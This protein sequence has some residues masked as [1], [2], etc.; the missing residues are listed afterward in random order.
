M[1]IRSLWIA[2]LLITAST[3]SFALGGSSSPYDCGRPGKLIAVATFGKPSEMKEELEAWVARQWKILPPPIQSLFQSEDRAMAEW[4][5]DARNR[6]LNAL[7]P[8]DNG[9]SW[10]L[11]YAVAGGNIAMVQW[12]VDEGSDPNAGQAGSKRVGSSSIFFR[13]P[14]PITAQRPDGIAADVAERRTVQAYQFLIEKGADLNRFSSFGNLTEGPRNAL[15]ECPNEA[16]IPVLLALGIDRSP[17]FNGKSTYYAPL[18]GAIRDVLNSPKKPLTRAKFL[19][20][21]GFN[22]LRGTEAELRMRKDCKLQINATLCQE[23]SKIVELSPGTIPGSE[24]R[25]STQALAIPQFRLRKEVCEFPELQFYPDYELVTVGSNWGG[26][27]LGLE[28]NW[29]DGG[30]NRQNGEIFEINITIHKPE[31]PVLLF[32]ENRVPT[33]WN[34]ARTK[35][36]KIIGV[37]VQAGYTISAIVGLDADI[38]TYVGHR[39]DKPVYYGNK[40]E[41]ID[42]QF[43]PSSLQPLLRTVTPNPIP[44]QGGSVHIGPPVPPQT[45][46]VQSAMPTPAVLGIRPLRASASSL[47]GRAALDVL[48]QEGWWERA[49]ASTFVW[50]AKNAIENRSIFNWL[51]SKIPPFWD[52]YVTRGGNLPAGLKGADA[53]ALFI[54]IEDIRGDPGD[55]TLFFINSGSDRRFNGNIVLRNCLGPMC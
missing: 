23:I 9:S 31:K 6:F 14:N 42:K 38:P 25:P 51:P 22:D 17:Q 12:L 26:K 45:P 54:S 43:D 24:G 20:Q 32:L 35:E 40:A 53:P 16:M 48:V 11:D 37:A 34:I 2:L 13:C 1:H 41:F 8:C 29:Q 50:W 33:I 10:L 46:L 5:K 28:F 18:Q 52:G 39:C 49:T 27:K 15:T 4:K 30:S 3:A 55:A 36:T 19:A 21:G 44:V 7:V 47:R